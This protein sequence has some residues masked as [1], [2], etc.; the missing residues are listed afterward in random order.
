MISSLHS[1]QQQKKYTAKNNRKQWNS[2]GILKWGE[3]KEPGKYYFQ[4][5]FRAKHTLVYVEIDVYSKVFFYR[6][7][8]FGE[9]NKND[10]Y[11]I[12][13]AFRWMPFFCCCGGELN[14][15]R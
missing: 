7:G 2:G 1:K 5:S 13:P 3:T 10:C 6:S 11:Y 15:T 8:W 9:I 14:K 4:L 12:E